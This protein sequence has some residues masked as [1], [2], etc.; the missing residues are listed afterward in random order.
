[1]LLSPPLFAAS[2]G[3]RFEAAENGVRVHTRPGPG[4]TFPEFRGVTVIRAGVFEILAVLD[5]IDRACE[6]TQRCAASRQLVRR[7]PTHRIFYNRTAVPWPLQDRDAVLEGKV[8]GMAGGVEV[9]ASFRSIR[10]KGMPAVDGV[11]R[12]PILAGAYRV[13]RVDD[14]TSIVSLRIRAHPGGIVPDWLAK[15]FAKRI[16]IDTLNGLRRQVARS[17]GRYRA[18][19]QRHSPARRGVALPGTPTLTLRP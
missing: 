3:W 10:Y 13:S 12:M 19:V 4:G 6:W 9:L 11:V 18:F 14:R 15:W 16:P 2:G 17:S 7:S 5:D 1:M 8:S